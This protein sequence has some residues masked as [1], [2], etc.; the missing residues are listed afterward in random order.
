MDK[1]HVPNAITI[2]RGVAALFIIT[3]F[4]SFI[5]ERFVAAYVLFICA[6]LSDFLDGYLARRWKVVSDFGAVFDPLFDKLLVLSLIVLIYPFDIVPPAILLILLVRDVSTDALKNYM[7]SHG[8]VTPAIYTAK[9]K[10]ASQ[11]LMFNFAL[12]ALAWPQVPYMKL[13]ATLTGFVAVF[14]SLWSG[15]VYLRR[16]IAFTRDR[17]I[18]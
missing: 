3:L 16:F 10:T 14:F 12:I 17:S 4:L 5:K 11:F 2:F 13:V 15:S 6:A 1:R 9:L 18:L 8:T 7:L